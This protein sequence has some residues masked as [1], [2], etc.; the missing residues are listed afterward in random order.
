MRMPIDSSLKAQPSRLLRLGRLIRQGVLG[1]GALVILVWV[2]VAYR[3]TRT[4]TD[5]LDQGAQA[6][7]NN[8]LSEASTWYAQALALRP[9]HQRALRG[10]AQAALQSGRPDEAVAWLEQAWRAEPASQLVQQ[11]LAIAYVNAGLTERGLKILQS[12]GPSALVIVGDRAVHTGDQAGALRW[13][14]Y[15]LNIGSPISSGEMVRI[16]SLLHA[17]GEI[18]R[19]EALVQRAQLPGFTTASVLDA[20]EMRVAGANLSRFVA[21]AI[22]QD[23]TTIAWGS[24]PQFGVLLNEYA[25][26]TWLKVPKDGDYQLTLRLRHDAPPPVLI[27]IELNV[28][29]VAMISLERGNFSWEERSLRLH[30]SQ[31]MQ[32][33]S[34]AFRNDYYDQLSDRNAVIEWIALRYLEDC[35][36]KRC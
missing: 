11:E 18:E 10:A 29:E 19:A 3:D 5:A 16:V 12:F 7:A 13:Y 22:V 4:F 30:L 2:L 20:A 25:G 33:L 28:Q 6:L 32:M 34:V 36:A 27:A 23:G 15:A 1:L 24:P 26:A 8:Q 35:Y 21:S 9:S 31:G 17:M 14:N